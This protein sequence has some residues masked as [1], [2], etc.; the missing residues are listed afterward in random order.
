MSIYMAFFY[1]ITIVMLV[2]ALVMSVT[3]FLTCS[4]AGHDDIYFF[5]RTLNISFQ[6]LFKCLHGEI[7]ISINTDIDTDSSKQTKQH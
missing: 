6:I 5:I 3:S 7:D 4:T 2:G 1:A